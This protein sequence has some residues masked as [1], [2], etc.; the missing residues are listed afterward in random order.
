[1]IYVVPSNG[2]PLRIIYKIHILNRFLKKI[3][4]DGKAAS[5]RDTELELYQVICMP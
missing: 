2:D 1:M 5:Y 3:F 4:C